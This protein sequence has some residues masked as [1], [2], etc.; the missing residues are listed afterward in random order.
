MCDKSSYR[1]CAQMIVGVCSCGEQNRLCEPAPYKTAY[2]L[3]MEKKRTME[4]K[5]NDNV[6]MWFTETKCNLCDHDIYTDGKL[7]WCSGSCRQNGMQTPDDKNY[8]GF[9]SDLIR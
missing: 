8:M 9:I 6:T 7:Y 4:K 1:D 5:K 2:E 3:L